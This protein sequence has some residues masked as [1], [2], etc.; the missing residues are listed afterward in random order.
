MNA[1]DAPQGYADADAIATCYSR[2]IG[3]IYRLASTH[4]WRRQRWH[5]RTIYH[6][7]DVDRTMTR[8]LDRQAA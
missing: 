6:L 3:S 4:N 8:T 5:G 2:P 1:L 7:D